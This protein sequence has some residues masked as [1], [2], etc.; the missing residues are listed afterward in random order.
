MKKF[1]TVIL[2]LTAFLQSAVLLSSPPDLNSTAYAYYTNSINTSTLIR[3]KLG[4]PSSVTVIGTSKPYYFGVGDWGNPAEIWNFYVCDNNGTRAIFSVDTLT[5]N[6]A[7]LGTMSGV[8]TGHSVVLMAWDNSTGKFY[9]ISSNQTV[10]Q[11]YSLNWPSFTLTAIGAPI[12]SCAYPVTGGFNNSGLLHVIDA[13]TGN[14]YRINKTTGTAQLIGPSGV[15]MTSVNDG[16]FDRTDNKFYCSLP[17][18]TFPRLLQMNSTLG[19]STIVG[20]FPYDGIAAMCVISFNPSSVVYN[21]EQ[22]SDYKLYNNYPNPFNPSTKIKFDI[23]EISDVKL[24]VYNMQGKELSVLVNE[25]LKP[26]SYKTT[27]N[28]S[29]FSSG[30]YYCVLKTGNYTNTIKLI[31]VK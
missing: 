6:V 29:N 25:R 13:S 28:G 18:G 5:G 2:L 15:A 22:V 27:F 17:A 23:P 1:L 12:T 20:I 9:I 3:F 24:S 4:T 21:P 7:N 11:L 8:L 16:A 14:I 10:S 31:L 19:E 26:G 30:T